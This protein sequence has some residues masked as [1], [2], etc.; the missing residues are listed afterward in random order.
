MYNMY[1]FTKKSIQVCI[2]IRYL[3]SIT[4]VSSYFGLDKRECE[5]LQYLFVIWWYRTDIV[6]K[7]DRLAPTVK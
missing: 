6:Q 2:L 5:C 7:H 1:V 4:Q 3:E